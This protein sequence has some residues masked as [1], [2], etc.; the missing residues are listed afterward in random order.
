MDPYD[1]LNASLPWLSAV[2]PISSINLANCFL[3]YVVIAS[4]EEF[5][6]KNLPGG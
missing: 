6:E 4:P 2:L 3:L 1:C 5:K